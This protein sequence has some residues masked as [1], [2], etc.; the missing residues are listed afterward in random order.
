MCFFMFYILGVI[1]SIWLEYSVY[2]GKV[3]GSSPELP[4]A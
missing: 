4:I 2:T 1:S 3:S